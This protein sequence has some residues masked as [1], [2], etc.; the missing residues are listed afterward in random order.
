[1]APTDLGENQDREGK[2]KP[3]RTK[4]EYDKKA[5]DAEEG[6]RRKSHA[7]AMAAGS[8]LKAELDKQEENQAKTAG[9]EKD[10]DSKAISGA[11]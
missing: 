8:T 3:R 4:A 9:H 11:A 5:A 7:E 1:M 6:A 10:L 2:E